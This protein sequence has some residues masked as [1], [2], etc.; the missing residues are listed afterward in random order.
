[1][2]IAFYAPMKSPDHPIPSGDRRMARLFM[3]ALEIAGFD[4]QVISSFRSFDKQGDRSFQEAKR[5]EAEQE[6]GALIRQFQA[7][8]SE[9]PDLFFTYHVYHKAPD[10]IGPK[11]AKALDIP[12]YIAEASH[13]PK[14]MNGRWHLGFAGA[15]AAIRAATRVLHLTRLDGAC[16][17]PL[18][19]QTD[20]LV[21]F[22]PFI[23]PLPDHS[24]V[25]PTA[26]W[27]EA[28]GGRTNCRNLL[29]VGMMR[30]GDKFNSYL[31]LAEMLLHLTSDNW[32]LLIV[33]DGPR[34]SDVETLFAPFGSN[35]VFLG[36]RSEAELAS[37]YEYADL[38]VWP[39]S[40]EAFGMAFLEAARAGLPAV[41]CCTRGVPD[42][43]ENGVSGILVRDGD[44]LALANATDQLLN[45]SE[46]LAALSNGAKAFVTEQ[47][48]LEAAAANLSNLIKKDVE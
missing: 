46:Q 47:R 8:P 9:R 30:D 48:S 5:A 3:R 4:V 16:L 36:E 28:A 14:Q 33:G 24:P 45:N 19:D 18:M 44:M 39:A 15:E 43:V 42:V 34:R 32:Q 1:M 26:K 12:Y 2:K 6:A 13:A 40:G 31:Q 27:V 7:D 11:V 38:Y 37:F 35:V 25:K 21:H 23:E 41:S 10:W 20:Q 17:Q 22:P 29:A